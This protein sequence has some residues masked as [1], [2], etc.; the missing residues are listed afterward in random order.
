MVKRRL[1]IDRLWTALMP[2]RA[3]HFPSHIERI[4]LHKLQKRGELSATEL[5]PTGRPTI[6]KLIAK[7]W[8]EPGNASGAYRITPAGEVALRAKLP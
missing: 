7:C 3:S 8:I 1:A 6:L 2:P 4:A 5:Y